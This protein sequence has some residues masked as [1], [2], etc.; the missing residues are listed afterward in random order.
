MG[1]STTVTRNR[2]EDMLD[3]VGEQLFDEAILKIKT[4]NEKTKKSI[5]MYLER[6]RN[7]SGCVRFSVIHLHVCVLFWTVFFF[8]L[9]NDAKMLL[10]PKC[11]TNFQRHD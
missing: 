9:Y 8:K 10:Y 4:K 3:E 11:L 2:D 7:I 5:S 1:G 6:F